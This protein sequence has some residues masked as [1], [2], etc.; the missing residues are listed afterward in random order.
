MN[1]VNREMEIKNQDLASYIRNNL[2][3]LSTYKM[4]NFMNMKESGSGGT[5]G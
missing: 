5:S 2:E 3:G 4:R 1:P